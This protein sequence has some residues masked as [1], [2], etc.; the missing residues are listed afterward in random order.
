[1]WRLKLKLS[2]EK[3]FMGRMAIKHKVSVTGYPLSYWKDKKYIYLISAGFIFGEES[4]KQSLIKDL[5]KQPEYVES[6]Q[7][8]D[9]IILTTKQPLFSEPVYNPK[10][11]RPNPVI[12]NKSGYHIWDLASFE[13]KE[14]EKVIEF[15]T[16]YL[17]AEI[18]VF[19]Q[20]K[21][22]NIEFTK[23]FPELTDNQKKA[24]QIAINSGY[25]DYPK[26]ITL[27]ELAEKMQIS[28]STFQAHLKKA[29]GR[30]FPS[31]LKEL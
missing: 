24:M 20:E 22:K 4:N 30:I 2:S 31:V 16:K 19:R 28:Y 6:E 8:G 26:K 14:L 5:K 1:M 9:F 3:Q 12:I 10:I 29:E 15:S 13:R 17:D 11:I 18:L 23:I 7:S 21:I 25:Y 27:P